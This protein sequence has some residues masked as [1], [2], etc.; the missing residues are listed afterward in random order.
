MLDDLCR[1]IQTLLDELLGEADKLR[2]ALAALRSRRRSPTIGERRTVSVSWAGSP[3][4]GSPH[5]DSEAR[6]V[7]RDR[8]YIARDREYSYHCGFQ[9]NVSSRP[10]ARRLAV[11]LVPRRARRRVRPRPLCFGRSPAV[12][13]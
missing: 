6:A 5:G 9:R 8:E 10:S 3:G 1:Q 13:R 4:L 11:Q 2:R 12:P 7:A